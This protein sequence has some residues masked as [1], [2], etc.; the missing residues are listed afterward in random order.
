MIESLPALIV[1][2]C[3]I[4]FSFIAAWLNGLPPTN[5]KGW[6]ART[7][8]FLRRRS[9]RRLQMSGLMILIGIMIPVGDIVPMLREEPATFAMYWIAV[10]LLIAWVIALAL[11]DWLSTRLHYRLTCSALQA[12]RQHLIQIIERHQARQTDM[13]TASRDATDP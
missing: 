11:G 9:R 6:D 3:L 2:S 8:S 5:Q 13:S 7:Q 12:Q 10:L 4:I 1:G